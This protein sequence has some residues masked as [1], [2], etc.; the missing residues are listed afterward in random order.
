MIWNL[1]HALQWNENCGI[2]DKSPQEIVNIT[3]LT[4]INRLSSL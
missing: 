4:F 2:I 1:V 3:M